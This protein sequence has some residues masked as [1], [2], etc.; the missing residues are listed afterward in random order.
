VLD[1]KNDENQV[2]MGQNKSWTTADW[3]KVIFLDEIKFNLFGSDGIQY[4]RRRSGERMK[5]K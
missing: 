4:V 3:Q 2:R 5:G 1:E